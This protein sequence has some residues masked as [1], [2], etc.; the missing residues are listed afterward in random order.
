MRLLL[1][2]VPIAGRYGCCWLVSRRK[3]LSLALLD[4]LC[5]GSVVMGYLHG[6]V[7]GLVEVDAPT[8][9]EFMINF[10]LGGHNHITTTLRS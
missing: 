3:G 4:K 1:N 9:S 7:D 5:V 6:D 2:S 10:L 8:L